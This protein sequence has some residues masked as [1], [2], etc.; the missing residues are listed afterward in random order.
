MQ[1]LHTALR[2]RFGDVKVPRAMALV[3]RAL[4]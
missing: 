2:T 4:A 3:W 1:A